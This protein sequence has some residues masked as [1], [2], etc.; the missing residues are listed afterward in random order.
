[1]KQEHVSVTEE[2]KAIAALTDEQAEQSLA[3]WKRI[4]KKG[5][6][7]AKWYDAYAALPTKTMNYGQS[8]VSFERSPE[9]EV[10]MSL[11]MSGGESIVKRDP[12]AGCMEPTEPQKLEGATYTEVKPLDHAAPTKDQTA[13]LIA[14]A[15]TPEGRLALARE[16]IRR[17]RAGDSTLDALAHGGMA[18]EER[19]AITPEMRESA[20]RRFAGIG[21]EVIIDLNSP[22]EVSQEDWDLFFRH[23]NAAGVVKPVTASTPPGDIAKMRS[24]LAD[25]RHAH[26]PLL[27]PDDKMAQLG[28]AHGYGAGPE[29]IEKIRAA[30]REDNDDPSRFRSFENLPREQEPARTMIREATPKEGGTRAQRRAAERR[31]DKGMAKAR[32]NYFAKSKNRVIK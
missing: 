5:A 27:T 2:A 29:T 31:R 14:F 23:A 16:L 21:E 26:V 24:M 7:Q 25:A 15:K 17:T 10:L 12:L 20:I 28:L 9:T 3:R 32:R 18:E 19:Q 1:M 11:D 30:F 13:A 6:A 4:T 8:P 22:H